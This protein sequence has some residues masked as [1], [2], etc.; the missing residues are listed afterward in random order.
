MSSSPTI[1]VTGASSGIGAAIAASFAAQGWRV[2][3]TMRRPGPLASP[4]CLALDVTDDAS[5]HACVAEVLARTGRIDALVNN[6]GITLMGAAEETS[7]A[8]AERVFATNFFGVHRM[9]CAVLP[10][11]RKQRGGRIVTIGSIAGFLPKPFEAFYSAAKHALEG[12]VESLDHEVRAL[13]IRALLI[14][15]GHVRSSLANNMHHAARHIA[16]YAAARCRA[17]MQLAQDIGGGVAA[18]A[19]ADAVCRAVT[20]PR[21]AHR[22]RVGSDAA[23]LHLLRQCAPAFVF[24]HG[25]RQRFGIAV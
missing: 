22:Y 14:E 16:D 23:R 15:P 3:P 2:F 18:A 13:G 12:Y 5:A 4:D 6:A 1:I 17:E 11:M 21:P 25:L 20:Q 10:Q 7:V 19:V 24:D 8:E 9:T